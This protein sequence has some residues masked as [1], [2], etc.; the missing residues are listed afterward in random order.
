MNK[1][2]ISSLAAAATIYAWSWYNDNIKY[3]SQPVAANYY[4]KWWATDLVRNQVKDKMILSVSWYGE[5]KWNSSNWVQATLKWENFEL[6]WKY[7]PNE[8]KQIAFIY[9]KR[10]TET[11]S[12]KGWLSYTHKTFTYNWKKLS[13]WD[14]RFWLSL[15]LENS[16]HKWE[17]GIIKWLLRWLKKANDNYLIDFIE[18]SYNNWKIYYSFWVI[19]Y[20][21]YWKNSFRWDVKM[22]FYPTKNTRVWVKYSTK[23]TNIKWNFKINAGLD[24]AFNWPENNP[25]S[26]SWNIWA[27]YSISKRCALEIEYRKDKIAKALELS[28]LFNSNLKYSWTYQQTYNNQEFEKRLKKSYVT[29]KPTPQTQNTQE[30]PENIQI[31]E[32]INLGEIN[33]NEGEK[34]YLIIEEKGW[35]ITNDIRENWKKVSANIFPNSDW[36]SINIDPSSVNSY[37]KHDIIVKIRNTKTGEVKYIRVKFDI[38]VPKKVNPTPEKLKAK[39][40]YFSTKYNTPFSGN[41]LKNDEG[42]KIK[43]VSHTTPKHGILK[44]KS[45]WDFEYIPHKGFS[46]TDSFNYTIK[47]KNGNKSTAT[48]YIKVWEKWNEAPKLKPDNVIIKENTSKIIDVLANDSDPDWDKL[49]ITSITQPHN[50]KAKIL[51]NKVKYT[52]NKGFSWKDSFKY[53]VDDWH[54]HKV[55]ANVNI[56]VEKINGAPKAKNFTEDANRSNSYITKTLPNHISDPDWDKLKVSIIGKNILW[57]LKI[58]ELKIIWN[59]I[60]VSVTSWTGEVSVIYKVKDWNWWSA[61]AI[62]K[63]IH[64]DWE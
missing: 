47:N 38:V 12:T 18:Y 53:T 2:I 52:P 1:W 62:A 61:T 59:Q 13:S 42:K 9:V 11:F 5:T 4:K 63:I 55:T 34:G 21:T 26:L 39:D 3:L 29:K 37:E 46:W 7:S 14:L 20:N 54:G 22:W 8:L 27:S 17:I 48:A 30:Q 41:L 51:G 15:L 23:P 24:Y 45:D 10:I 64:L 35:V 43:I 28:N 33:K 16:N 56:T 49:T 31:S 36:K 19:G 60:F 57:D 44:I 40:D 58:W 6:S 32:V 50:W 25:N